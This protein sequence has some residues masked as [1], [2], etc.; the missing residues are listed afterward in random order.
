MKQ[1]W[2]H[3][4]RKLHKIA[5]S[6]LNVLVN[7][8]ADIVNANEHSFLLFHMVSYLH[9]QHQRVKSNGLNAFGK[10]TIVS[11]QSQQNNTDQ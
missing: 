10:V 9:L 5:L 3:K 11:N 6:L 1:K 4:A 7:G 8:I 2:L